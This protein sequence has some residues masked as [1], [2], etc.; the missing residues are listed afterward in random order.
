MFPN[1]LHFIGHVLIG[2]RGKRQGLKIDWTI[3][4]LLELD[5]F[6]I[7][8]IMIIGHVLPRHGICKK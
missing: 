6:I 8:Q 7:Y 5:A 1:H 3:Q 2:K 4:R